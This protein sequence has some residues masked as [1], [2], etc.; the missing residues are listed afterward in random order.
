MPRFSDFEAS[1]VGSHLPSIPGF[2]GIEINFLK[3]RAMLSVPLSFGILQKFGE[4][5]EL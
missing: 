5:V 2:F 1:N 3:P 4:N